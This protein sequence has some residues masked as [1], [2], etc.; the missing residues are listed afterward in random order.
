MCR[1]KRFLDDVERP[2]ARYRA[3]AAAAAAAA[4]EATVVN[5]ALLEKQV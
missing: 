1:Y 2:F 3:A 5:G 4:I